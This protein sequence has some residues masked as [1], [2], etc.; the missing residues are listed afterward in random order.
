MYG[1]TLRIYLAPEDKTQRVARKR[2]GGS[3]KLKYT[4]G[5]VEFEDRK[6]ARRVAGT[7]NG[8][9]IG[10]KKRHNKWHDDIWNMKY[11]PKFKWHQLKETELYN[12]QV[13]KARL[14][15]KVSQARREN[16]FYLEKVEQAKSR[17]MAAERRKAKGITVG[18]EGL[19]DADDG[20]LPP[21]G[22]AKGKGRGGARD[23]EEVPELGGV[24]D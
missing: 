15:Q 17:K 24:S 22:A 1:K 11:L 2:R 20:Q 13:R 21:R 5:W 12:F 18:R 8:T 4:E 14:Q 3:K 19:G 23:D 10:G 7:L 16:D 6:I 9:P